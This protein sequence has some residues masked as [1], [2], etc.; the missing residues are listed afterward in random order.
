[1]SEHLYDIRKLCRAES[2]NGR[3][4]GPRQLSPFPDAGKVRIEK[5]PHMSLR[6][7][8][9]CIIWKLLP[10]TPLYTMDHPKFIV[11]NQKEESIST[12]RVNSVKNYMKL[13]T[14]G[15]EVINFPCSTQLSMK[16][17]LLINVKMPAIVSMINT[18][19]ERIKQ[20]LFWSVF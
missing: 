17:I 19:S 16:F 12:Q 18:T 13:S 15:P 3:K 9:Y 10:V 8:K 2:V 5:K 20:E 14:S 1:M 7:K 4:T 6:E 11:T